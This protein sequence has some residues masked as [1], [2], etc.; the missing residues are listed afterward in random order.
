MLRRNGKLPL[1]VVVFLVMALAL[2]A[3]AGV[4]R[5]WRG[6]RRGFLTRLAR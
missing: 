1:R 4:W 3:G 6:C 5:C 2:F